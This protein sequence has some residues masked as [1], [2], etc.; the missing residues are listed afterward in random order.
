MSKPPV[1]NPDNNEGTSGLLTGGLDNFSSDRFSHSMD[2]EERERE[3]ESSNVFGIREDQDPF[4]D[5][6]LGNL[7]GLDS[8]GLSNISSSMSRMRPSKDDGFGLSLPLSLP[9]PSSSSLSHNH[10]HSLSNSS[11]VVGSRSFHSN[12]LNSLGLTPTQDTSD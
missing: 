7:N 6:G 5:Q 9:L 8:L 2:S 11:S 3:R 1:N 12:T 4:R 10:S